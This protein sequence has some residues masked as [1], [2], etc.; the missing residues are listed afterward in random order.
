MGFLSHLLPKEIPFYE[1]LERQNALLQKT[2]ELLC[3][4]AELGPG[5]EHAL[6]QLNELEEE[7]DQLNREIVWQLSQ[8][9]ITPIDREDIGAL[10]LSQERAID[11]I[12][13]L[14]RRIF[15]AGFM[16]TKFPAQRMLQNMHLMTCDTGE[17][18]HLLAV[19]KPVTGPQ[20]TLK[21]RKEEIIVLLAN[22]LGELLDES[23]SSPDA[24]REAMLWIQIYDRIE[25]TTELVSDLGDTLEQVV[26]KYV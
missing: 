12:R 1:L 26:L 13:S 2:A 10:N 21:M 25:T 16:Y 8:T 20:H 5:A 11:G 14:A 15:L 7:A 22:G 17:M 23:L 4:V 9:F 24:V 19:K 18:L 3:T 6:R